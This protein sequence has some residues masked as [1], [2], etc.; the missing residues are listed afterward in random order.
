M[1]LGQI[2]KINILSEMRLP[3]ISFRFPAEMKSRI[4]IQMSVF[5]FLG[6]LNYT[7]ARP[8][9]NLTPSEFLGQL[10]Y[11][12]AGPTCDLTSSKHQIQIRPRPRLHFGQNRDLR[13]P[14]SE[15]A[16]SRQQHST[17]ICSLLRDSHDF[18]QTS[19]IM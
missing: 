6:Q 14:I 19:A 8:T 13:T 3:V 10:N 15:S 11:N 5:E 16:S 18:S 4:L 2:N 1:Q 12:S 17:S 7:S 9:C